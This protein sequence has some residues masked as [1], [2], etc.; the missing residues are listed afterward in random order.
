[1]MLV[2]DFHTVSLVFFA[3]L[4]GGV[5]GL[6]RTA[7]GQI[8]VSQ[9]LVAGP[10]TGWLLGDFVTGAVIGSVLELIW[11]LDLPIGTFVPA[12]ATVG[13]VAAVA[14]A[15]LG[16]QG[17]A[18]L[19]LI[20]F[21]IVLTTAMVPVT[22]MADEFVRKR[23]ARLAEAAVAASGEDAACRLSRA[24]LTGLVVFFLKSFLL[25]LL[26]IPA[27]LAAVVVFAQLPDRVHR[28]MELFV[29]S[30]PLLG[31]AL[32]LHKLSLS[33]VDRF[34]FA[35]F[36]AA[37]ALTFLIPGH[38]AVVVTVVALAGLAG[39]RWWSERNL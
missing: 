30:L 34:F 18:S 3:A 13:T 19:D 31:A 29:K 16:G 26:I 4:L 39:L 27:G 8:M 10:V 1:M 17:K 35:G 15:V 2:F 22:M 20:G 5:I 21:S 32:I 9:P 28:G 12:D 25:C 24:H 7:A 14:I 33:V 38:P 6:D 37:L 23:N 11:V 36:A